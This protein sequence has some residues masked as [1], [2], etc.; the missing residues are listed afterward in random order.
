MN[1]ISP[2]HSNP[3]KRQVACRSFT[4]VSELVGFGLA[5]SC[6]STLPLGCWSSMAQPLWV[7]WVEKKKRKIFVSRFWQGRK[8]TNLTHWM[9]VP[10]I[11]WCSS[12]LRGMVHFDWFF[13]MRWNHQPRNVTFLLLDVQ[14]HLFFLAISNDDHCSWKNMYVFGWSI[15]KKGIVATGFAKNV[16]F[17]KG[18]VL[19]MK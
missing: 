15:K 1:L 6:L 7:A 5:G 9:V 14:F 4:S 10:N 12:I 3:E 17:L 11:F 19:R 8:H 2:S 16:P 18:V 13:E